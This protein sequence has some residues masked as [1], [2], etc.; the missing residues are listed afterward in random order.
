VTWEELDECA[1]EDF[2]LRTMPARFAAIGDRHAAIDDHPCD[3]GPLLVLSKK[4]EAEGQG[5][6][7]WPP[8]YAKQVGEPPRVAPS[9]RKGGGKR[10][11]A[12]GSVKPLVEVSRSRRKEDALAALER[13]KSRHPQAVAHL[14]P[15]DVLVDSMRGRSS[16]W[17]R[18]RVN[19]EHVPEE[20]RPPPEPL[21]GDYDPWARI[22]ARA[23]GQRS[24][25]AR[26]KRSAASDSD[27]AP[28]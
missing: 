7:P 6:A 18:V 15:A 20:L 11:G 13:W 24:A 16:T 22:R 4:Q 8:H 5:D 25:T 27:S 3:L 10:S 26:R 28:K 1:P 12:R 23:S 17:T 14:A 21:D 9:R 19:L 2:T